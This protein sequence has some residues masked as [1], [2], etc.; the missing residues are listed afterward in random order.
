MDRSP[1][2]RNNITD[3][4][5]TDQTMTSKFSKDKGE[6]EHKVDEDPEELKTDNDNKT[7]SN[8]RASTDND[9]SKSKTEGNTKTDNFQSGLK[10]PTPTENNPGTAIE[11]SLVDQSKSNTDDKSQITDGQKEKLRVNFI[12][13]MS[14]TPTPMNH[15]E[16]GGDTVRQSLNAISEAPKNI[17]TDKITLYQPSHFKDTEEQ[18]KKYIEEVQKHKRELENLEKKLE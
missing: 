14:N 10:S 4:G 9:A 18:V 8:V 2:S 3:M 13:E 17:P 6:V 15:S 5:K 1:N 16:I 11:K 12:K 7:V